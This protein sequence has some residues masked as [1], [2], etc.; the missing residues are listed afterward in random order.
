[1]YLTPYFQGPVSIFNAK[2][3]WSAPRTVSLSRPAGQGYGFSVRGDCPVKIA[4][5][6]PGG[7]AEVMLPDLDHGILS[8]SIRTML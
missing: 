1:M 4:E 2:N 7:V 3:H 6:E 8:G 5:I